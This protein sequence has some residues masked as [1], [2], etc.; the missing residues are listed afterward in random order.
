[1]SKIVFIASVC[2]A[3]VLGSTSARADAATY[4]VIVNAQAKVSQLKK[5]ELRAIYLKKLTRW[6]DDTLITPFDL[7][8]AS[9]VRDAFTQ[10]AL[11][12]TKAS[13]ISQWRQR[14]FTGQGVPPKELADDAA[15]MTVVTA[16]PGA[17]GYVRADTPVS[18]TVVVLTITD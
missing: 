3:M 8:V 13:L 6:K 12:M 16:T 7:P 5:S 11:E 17:I 10:G 14:I 1:M 9:P 2:V 18:P 15:M 4:K